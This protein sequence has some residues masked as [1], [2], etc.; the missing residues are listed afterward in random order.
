MVDGRADAGDGQVALVSGRII[1]S[2]S[3]PAFDG[4]TA[5]IFLEDISYADADA[6]ILSHTAVT[7]IDHPGASGGGGDR[8]SVV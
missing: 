2:P 1:I 4:A 3:V 8:K 6:Q 5:H 7:G